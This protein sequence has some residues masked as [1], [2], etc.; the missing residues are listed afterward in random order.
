MFKT[1]F[2]GLM[3]HKLRMALTALAVVLGVGFIAGTFVL[4]DTMN[5]AFDDLFDDVTRG[6]DVY[7]RGSSDFEAAFGGSRQPIDDDLLETVQGV[8]GVGVAAG[9]VQGYAQIIDKDGNAITPGGAPTLGFNWSPEPL[10][11]MTVQ[12]GSPPARPD[13]VLID[14]NT[15]EKYDFRIGDTVQVITLEEPREFTLTGIGSFGSAQSLGGS[16]AAIFDTPTAQELFDKEEQFDSI[17]V[18][19]ESGV[20]EEELRDRLAPVL[21]EGVEADTA[22]SVA[23]EQSQAIQ[24]GL[25]F[26]NTALL[27]FASISLFVG[28][29]LIYNTFSITVAQRTR[30]FALLRA[31][32][33][34]GGQ[35]M[36]SVVIEALIVGIVAAAVGLA[37]GILIAVGLNGL[38]EA[39]G[40]DL[41]QAGLELQPRTI[42][43]AT[44]VGIVITLVSA[45]LP[46]RRAASISPMEALRESAPSTY[47]PSRRRMILGSLM[48]ALGA[49]TLFVGLFAE[50]SQEIRYVGAGAAI[51]FFGVATLAPVFARPLALAIGAPM[52]RL[53]N[54]PGRLAQQNAARNPK[55]T[56][57][58]AAALMIGLALV[59][60]VGIFAASSKASINKVLD[61][62]MKADFVIQSTAFASQV[63]SPKLAE[64]LSQRSEIGAVAPFRFGQFRSEGKG[65]FVIAT[66]PQALTQTA[67]IG[68]VGGDLDDL[69]GGGVFLFDR[70]AE[71]LGVGLGDEFEM[72]FAPTGPQQLEVV[73]LFD[74]KSLVGGDYLVSL[75]TYDE[76]FSERIDTSIFI[77]AAPGTS[78]DDARAAVE[79]VTQA[80]PNVEVQNQAEAKQTYAAQIDQLLGLVTALLALALVIA[81][82][83][84]TNTLAL[85][86]YERTREL[87]LLRAVGMTRKQTK[88]MIRWEAVIIVIIGAI[89]GVAIGAFFG[90]ALV[91][92]LGDEGITEFAIP[93]SQLV[94]YV[95]VAALFGIIAAIPPAR[96]AA[97]LN[98]LDAIA[99]E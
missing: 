43:V 8:D 37:A 89:L 28:A 39:F 14:A 94:V 40:I 83:G 93:G 15:A 13:Q 60:F 46:A 66:D 38:L 91:Q 61:E 34:S 67:N 97:R 69:E 20:G 57:A 70:T 18:A 71:S 62:S 3:A 4:T 47:R 72:Q 32:G 25:S 92:A 48:T 52:H 78:I 1:T 79:D 81:V 31:L 6:T 55:R 59:G 96:R 22:T 77:K 24:E 2:K 19:A 42:V 50:V 88:S 7:V 76:N 56:S 27:I 17:D 54:M 12:S 87:G 36:G 10:N 95:V 51:I 49:A 30:E 29:F 21:P 74:D 33:A 73:G 9:S 65:L 44:T 35:V 99:T 86:V 82:L 5:A 84:I 53:F 23:D 64:D 45:V 75:G 58:T 80:Y 11:P 68:V 41:P 26:F 90:W 98:V 63:I 85:S 16:T